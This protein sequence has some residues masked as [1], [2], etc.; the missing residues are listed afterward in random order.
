M[1]EQGRGEVSYPWFLFCGRS[2]A[3]WLFHVQDFHGPL[4]HLTVPKGQLFLAV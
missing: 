3:C 4:A 1:V 2:L